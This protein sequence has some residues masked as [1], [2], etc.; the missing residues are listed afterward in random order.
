MSEQS[1][2]HRIKV[3]AFGFV[4]VHVC[5]LCTNFFHLEDCLY[6]KEYFSGFSRNSKKR[7]ILCDID[8]LTTDHTCL[9]MIILLCRSM[10]YP[11]VSPLVIVTNRETL[12]YCLT[13][14]RITY[15]LFY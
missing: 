13:Y 4:K 14:Q 10:P 1:I 8:P 11:K 6:T 9:R 3:W 5:T 7:E 12:F 15:F 2:L